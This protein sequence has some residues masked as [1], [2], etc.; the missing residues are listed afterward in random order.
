[1]Q[2][3]RV[4]ASGVAGAVAWW[5]GIVAVFGPAQTLLADPTRQSAKFLAAF[6][7]PPLPRMAEDPIVVPIG[8]L[9]LG[10][11]HAVAYTW[12]EPKLAGAWYRRGLTFGLLAFAL[13]TP[14]FEFYLPWNVMLEPLSLV[15]LEGACWLVV[16]LLVG[17][18]IAGVQRLLAPRRPATG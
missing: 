17:L 5:L 15:L 7:E 8:L 16:M 12:L 11:I 10:L 4:V 6:T 14:W 13:M 18:A 3:I 9:L 2:P 1:M